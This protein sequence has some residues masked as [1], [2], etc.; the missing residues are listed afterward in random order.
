MPPITKST[1]ISEKTEDRDSGLLQNLAKQPLSYLS[2]LICKKRSAEK[3]PSRLFPFE[4]TLYKFIFEALFFLH[5]AGTVRRV[6]K[7][8]GSP[9]RVQNTDTGTGEPSETGSQKE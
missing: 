7:P 4:K 5:K 9:R 2:Y 8:Q 1:D 3:K 6:R